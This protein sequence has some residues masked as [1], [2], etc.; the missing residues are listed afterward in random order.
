[1]RKKLALFLSFLLILTPLYASSLSSKKNELSN[2]QKEIKETKNSLALT[3]EKKKQIKEEIKKVDTQIVGIQDKIDQLEVQLAEKEEA[4]EKSEAA[5]EVATEKKEEQY[6]DTKK[7]MVQMYKN[8]KI[9]YLQ[10]VFSSGSFWEALNRVEYIKRISEKD[11][12]TLVSYEEQIRVIDEQKKL[13]EE[14]KVELDTLFEE[15][16]SRK[17]ELQAAREEKDKAISQL[18]GEEDK[19]KAQ[20]KEMEEESKKL[21]AEIKRL[22]AASNLKYAGGKFG[23]PVPG[24]YQLSSQYNSRTSPISGLREFHTGI[25]IPASYGSPVV[26][27]ADGVVITSGWINGYGYTIMINHGSGLVSLYGH[28][29][30]LVVQK[31]DTVKKGQTVA[32]IGSTGYSTGNHCHFEVRV[33]GAHTSPWN[34]LSKK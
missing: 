2:T 12:N 10:I 29:S 8:R 21:E 16:V 18:A 23:W 25:D 31:G 1:M 19:L 11:N 7:R 5:L 34:Y 22:T 17:H 15:Q 9:G 3:E 14:E 20:I 32:K 24:F 26:A 13:I 30:S 27:A 4:I 6:E 33:N 28:N